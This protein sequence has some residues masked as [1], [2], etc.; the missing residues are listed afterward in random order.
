M[1]LDW[2]SFTSQIIEDPYPFYAELR[3]RA[4]ICRFQRDDVRFWVLTRYDDVAEVLRDP[5]MSV[6]RYPERMLA[7]AIVGPDPSFAALARIVSSVLL[8]KDP[9]AHTR[10]RSLVAKAFTPR[11]VEALRPR[12]EQTLDEL[13]D[14]VP[15]ERSFDLIADVAA[16]LPIIVIAELLGVPPSDRGEFKR[17]SDDFVPFIDGSI[18]D[19]GLERAAKAAVALTDYF[20]QVIEERR[21]SPRDDLMSAL[22][23]AEEQGDVLSRQELIATAVLL[24]A[25]GHETTTNLIGNGMLALLRHPAELARLRSEPDLAGSAVEELL[26]FDS[27]VQLTS[28]I[29]QEPIEIQ[30]QR[31]PAGEEVNVVLAAAN[32]DPARFSEPDRLD[33]GRRDN[34]HLSFGYGT[35]FCLGASL[36]RLEAQTAFAGLLRRFP[37]LALAEPAPP[38]KP[39]IVLRGVR[40]L[41]LHA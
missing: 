28:R 4:P 40:A 37:H 34:R 29:P 1:D 2:I 18:R 36:A 10:L 33:L 39:G 17:W 26:R 11:M 24:L 20:T 27:P 8:V 13:L 41:R 35:H 3:R 19:Q 12:I 32:R 9:P 30:G 21:K 6:A 15:E 22:V 14:A 25:A 7:D 31:I 38:W 23:A 16:P 5:R